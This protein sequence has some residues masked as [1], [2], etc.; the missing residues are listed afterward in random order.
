MLSDTAFKEVLDRWQKAIL[1]GRELGMPRVNIIYKM[2]KW[3]TRGAA[4]RGAPTVDDDHPDVHC[5]VRALWQLKYTD[6][7]AYKAF[8]AKYADRAGEI[9]I[10]A[11]R[12]AG[13]LKDHHRAEFL[14]CPTTTFSSRCKRGKKYLKEILPNMLESV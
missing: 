9:T 14:G 12:G 1:A 8:M 2:R 5:M 7:D 13:R 11:P 3:G 4:Q 6:E 10:P